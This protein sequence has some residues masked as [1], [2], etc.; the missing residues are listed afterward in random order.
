MVEESELELKLELELE[1]EVMMVVVVVVVVDEVVE[2][3]DGGGG[4]FRATK[5]IIAYGSAVTRGAFPNVDP[6]VFPTLTSPKVSSNPVT[7]NDNDDHNYDDDDDDWVENNL[8][9]GKKN[10]ER[11]N[12]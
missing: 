6:F 7:D 11:V 12:E 1:L 8:R 10:N 2:E 5:P 9:C 3:V 4:D